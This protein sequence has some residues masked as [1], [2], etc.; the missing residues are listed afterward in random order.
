MVS[1]K[2]SLFLSNMSS[3]LDISILREL[4]DKVFDVR[5]LKIENDNPVFTLLSRYGN[6]I[7]KETSDD[8]RY[9]KVQR[10]QS[11]MRGEHK[12]DLRLAQ[13][14][15]LL[16]WKDETFE[17]TL[18]AFEG[19]RE[20]FTIFMD[21][22]QVCDAFFDFIRHSK[23][24]SRQKNAVDAD[25][26]V[27]KVLRNGTWRTV[28]SYPKR[29]IE[30]IIT[31]DN[32]VF[33]IV[34]DMKTFANSEGEYTKYGMPFKRN[35]LITGP[36]GSGKSSIITVA[37][38]ELDLDVCFITVTPGMDEKEL[39]TAVSN[40]TDN[41]MLVLEDADILCSNS[42][43]NGG[44]ATNALAVLTNVL[45]GC[46]H[47]HKLITVLTSTQPK[48]LESVLTRHGRIDYVCRLDHLDQNQTREM[49][50]WAV[51]DSGYTNGDAELLKK[52]VEHISSRIWRELTSIGDLSSTHVAQFLFRNR[53]SIDSL[54]TSD[55]A[56][57]TL[58]NGTRTK[59][60]ETHAENN[61]VMFM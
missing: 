52:C 50:K 7:K 32:K 54:M 19:G 30:S 60:V 55:K 23:E 13:G 18:E 48:A 35:Y 40:L 58:Q 25:K 53:K 6:L 61:G 42:F 12:L 9:T 44:G 10:V 33:D 3:G 57:K 16:S 46:L 21:N 17:V 4:E 36:P 34:Q 20:E 56:F 28:S 39:C 26:I 11:L 31:G 59:H 22:E 5:E 37:A 15:H 47:R 45:D 29:S 24:F 43:S 38:G 2:K 8:A 41:A 51:L 1:K 27:V 14:R 49:T